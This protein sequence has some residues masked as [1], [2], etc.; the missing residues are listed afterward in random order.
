MK[1]IRPIREED[2]EG[3]KTLAFTAHTGMSLPKDPELLKQKINDSTQAF[4][5]E[6]PDPHSL[7][8]TFVLE[9]LH[10]K[11]IEGTCSIRARTG[12]NFPFYFYRIETIKHVASHPQVPDT[13]KIL[14]IVKYEK[15][16]SEICALY[17]L[18]EHRKE[19]FGRL[20]SL[21]RFFFMASHPERFD[22]QVY[23][24][25]RGE[26]SSD[27]IN[28]FWE[29][30]G[31]HF[32]DVSIDK[33]LDYMQHH[34][35]I[36][37]DILPSFPIYISVLPPN[38]QS[39]LGG[40]HANT[41]AAVKLLENEGFTFSGEINI[42]DGGPKLSCPVSQVRTIRESTV[43]KLQEIMLQPQLEESP[44]YLISNQNLDFRA[45][46]GKLHLFSST[47]VG[48]SAEMADAVHLR[49]GDT[50]RYLKSHS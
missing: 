1:I 19:G 30:I 21:S 23:G 50:L 46:Q 17:M 43:A 9:D 14:R 4:S 34:P 22:S 40:I 12:V 7:L 3:F 29:G 16:P 20:L 8:Y 25:M 33:A 49:P 18:P 45:S 36:I 6:H 38:V 5:K 31:R 15:G 44:D 35:E 32:F 24:D 42:L 11:R 27:T 13:Q 37:H 2:Y 47:S 48:L 39:S 41:K 28:A 10:S 26:F